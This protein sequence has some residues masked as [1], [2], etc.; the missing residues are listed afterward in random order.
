MKVEAGKPDL[1]VSFMEMLNMDDCSAHAHL[2]LERTREFGIMNKIRINVIKKS[3]LKNS[4]KTFPR[5]SN[6]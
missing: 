2:F 5:L 4:S 3:V 6:Q 1:H